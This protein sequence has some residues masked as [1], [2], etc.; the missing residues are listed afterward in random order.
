MSNGEQVD[1]SKI[2][3]PIPPGMDTG[4][5]DAGAPDL[6]SIATPLT[7]N[8]NNEG[9]YSMTGPDDEEEEIQIPFSRVLS[10]GR[11]GYKLS[12]K[13]YSRFT[14]DF[15]HAHTKNKNPPGTPETPESVFDNVP[16]SEKA[17]RKGYGA[18]RT[19]VDLLPT[20]GAIAGGIL[21]GVPGAATGPADLAIAAAGAAA[22][23]GLGEVARQQIDD[24]VFNEKMTPRKSAEH[25]GGQAAL[26]ATTEFGGRLIGVPLLKS[27][28]WFSNAAQK[29]AAAGFRLL[30]SEAQGTAA[31]FVERYA[32]ASLLSSGRMAAW[33]E[34]QNRETTAAAEKLADDISAS[35]VTREQ[36]GELIQKGIESY[37]TA[38]RAAQDAAYKSIDQKVTQAG[39]NPERK[40]LVDFAKQEL[41]KIVETKKAGGASV[42]STRFENLLKDIVDNP[43]LVASYQGMARAR[44]A[45][46]DMARSMT[47][48][49]SGAE[50]G[51]VQKL[52]ELADESMM[53]AAIK[54]GVP[55]LVNEVRAANELTR[56]THEKFEQALIKKIVR[57]REP[58]TFTALLTSPH[59]S[60]EGVETL[61]EMLP[62][63]YRPVIQSNIIRDFI[64]GAT[65]EGKIGFNERGFAKKVLRLGD[66]KGTAIFGSNWKNIRGI[67]GIMSNI[68]GEST[69][70][71]GA[72]E[73][74]NPGMAKEAVIKI[75]EI[76]LHAAGVPVALGTGRLGTFLIGVGAE[77]AALNIFVTA[78][79]KPAAAARVLRGLQILGRGALY[80]T[81]GAINAAMAQGDREE[82]AR[83]A[84]GKD[85]AGT[86]DEDEAPAK[87]PPPAEAKPPAGTPKSLPLAQLNAESAQRNPSAP[88]NPPNKE[89]KSVLK[90]P[91]TGHRVG[92]DDNGQSWY[93]VVTGQRVD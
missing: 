15:Y 51:A 22:G 79:Q 55:G 59:I 21:T 9:T 87:Q 13:D 53:D 58:S 65:G 76:A 3:R 84:E 39:I 31:T 74:A 30:P 44:S 41:A 26:G 8:P 67:A 14:K 12:P 10:L 24:W 90:D 19:A 4:A 75:S 81:S 71:G 78:L 82:R 27:A 92:S 42:V 52:G 20:A 64:T 1:L 60:R 5:H 56:T 70:R 68:T 48:P 16:A 85:Q 47:E 6:G 23:A 49:L 2:A 38:F 69:G 61:M 40:G 83:E 62:V 37:R 73:L 11:A 17:E 72:A 63:K 36:A 57:S 93:D 7:A 77:G 66:D 86:E 46:L 91:K 45:W 50:K 43:D 35:K 32:K 34:A 25:I 54:S 18:I 29:S 33:R 28:Q 80:A 89:Y 88:P